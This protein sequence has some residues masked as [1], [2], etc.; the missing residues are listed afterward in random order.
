M[1]LTKHGMENV[2]VREDFPLR[3][4][5]KHYLPLW[6]NE[7]PEGEQWLPPRTTPDVAVDGETMKSLG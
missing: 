5:S 7:D 1:V 3:T 2:G 4:S 6:N